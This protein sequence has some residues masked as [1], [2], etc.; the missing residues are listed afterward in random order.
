MLAEIALGGGDLEEEAVG[1][2]T[3][4]GWVDQIGNRDGDGTLSINRKRS[5]GE[6]TGDGD[7]LLVVGIEGSGGGQQARRS[8]IKKA[9]H[10][11]A[12]RR[13]DAYVH[14]QSHHY[15]SVLSNVHH[16]RHH[17]RIHVR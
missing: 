15:S 3:D 16:R 4:T 9:G 5:L 14:R 10:N 13:V 7:L 17:H 8:T 12:R 1:A 11:Q 6:E 2:S